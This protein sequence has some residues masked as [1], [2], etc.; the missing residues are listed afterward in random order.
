VDEL[1]EGV[2]EEVE[3]DD[4]DVCAYLVC[5]CCTAVFE[6]LCHTAIVNR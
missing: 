3:E 2:V 1:E 4:E 5:V 6:Q